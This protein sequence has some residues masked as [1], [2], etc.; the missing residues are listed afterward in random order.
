VQWNLEAAGRLEA[1]TAV[2]EVESM[3]ACCVAQQAVVWSARLLEVVQLGKTEKGLVTQRYYNVIVPVWQM[4]AVDVEPE[5]KSQD[6]IP[7]FVGIENVGFET[8]D[9]WVGYT[10]AGAAG[11]SCF[12]VVVVIDEEVDIAHE[13]SSRSGTP[14]E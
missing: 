7:D 6:W 11:Q 8:V 14:V 9:S 4:V 10:L 1:D 2:A 3:C 13:T 5:D 12:G